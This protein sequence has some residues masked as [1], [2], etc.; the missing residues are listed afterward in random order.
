[1]ARVVYAVRRLLPLLALGLCQ[2]ACDGYADI[3]VPERE[4]AGF[5]ASAVDLHPGA[6]GRVQIDLQLP[7]AARGPFFVLS[8]PQTAGGVIRV[9]NW[10]VGP[11]QGLAPA[12][13]GAALTLCVAVDA[14]TAAEQPEG[15][16]LSLVV[17]ARGS[18]QRFTVTGEVELP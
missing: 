4:T 12:D 17:D 3:R 2:A 10:M 9:A 7:D 14:A 1:M 18:G 16:G 11:C 15:F 6:V 13:E 5:E 8:P